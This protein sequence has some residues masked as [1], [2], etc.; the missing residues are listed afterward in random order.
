[1]AFRMEMP[2]KRTLRGQEAPSLLMSFRATYL[3]IVL[4]WTGSRLL[5]SP[6]LSFP[7]LRRGVVVQLSKVVSKTV[8]VLPRA[9]V[10]C[11]QSMHGCGAALQHG[12]ARG[13]V[14][15][16]LTWH[17]A[18]I[19]SCQYSFAHQ[20]ALMYPHTT[21][22]GPGQHSQCKSRMRGPPSAP[23]NIYRI[24]FVTA[25]NLQLSYPAPPQTLLKDVVH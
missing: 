23:S 16:L 20:I 5:V 14:T 22:L 12:A 21:L 17:P 15:T 7:V 10:S 19:A 25:P 24:A 3:Q 18:A 8:R 9:P 11:K 4:A 2:K 6:S 1:M 13:E